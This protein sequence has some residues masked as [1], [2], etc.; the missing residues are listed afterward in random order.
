MK[1]KLDES[2][3][4]FFNISGIDEHDAQVVVGKI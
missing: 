2:K 1:S 3:E 4:F